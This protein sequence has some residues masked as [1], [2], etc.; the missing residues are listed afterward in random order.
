MVAARF[1]KWEKFKNTMTRHSKN[2]TR[3]QGIRTTVSVKYTYPYATENGLL[4]RYTVE[5]GSISN[6]MEDKSFPAQS[7][8]YFRRRLYFLIN[9]FY[10]PG[11]VPVRFRTRNT[12]YQMF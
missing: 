4:Y 11:S 7:I 10:L 5:R 2:G 8:V 6:K 9:L 3:S 1:L 12:S